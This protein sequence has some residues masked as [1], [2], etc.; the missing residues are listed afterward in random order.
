MHIREQRSC[1]AVQAYPYARSACYISEGTI[2]LRYCAGFTINA[3]RVYGLSSLRDHVK[4]RYTPGRYSAINPESGRRRVI[5]IAS[6]FDPLRARSRSENNNS[7]VT[8]RAKRYIA[9]SS[10]ASRRDDR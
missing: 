10:C 8:E 6:S 3:N 9:R 1:Q 5:L 7:S 2:E 4:F